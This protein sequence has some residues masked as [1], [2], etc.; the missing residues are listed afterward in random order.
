[1]FTE[2]WLN[3]WHICMCQ[4]SSQYLLQLPVKWV[5]VSVYTRKCQLMARMACI[6]VGVTKS[7]QESGRCQQKSVGLVRSQEG[8]A[9]CQ[10]V[11]RSLSFHLNFY[12]NFSN[13]V[14][15]RCIT[16]TTKKLK[17][18]AA[19]NRPWQSARVGSCCRRCIWPS[20]ML[21]KACDDVTHCS[22]RN[23]EPL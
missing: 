1:M 18:Q 19:L 15:L 20:G 6:E 23:T 11:K 4:K 8:V 17:L 16:K 5:P 3:L 22:S 2:C 7:Q 10:I 12:I 14:K 13:E 21:V 9:G